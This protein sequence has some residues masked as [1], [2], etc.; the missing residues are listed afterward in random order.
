MKK[1]IKK[2]GKNPQHAE[3]SE[4]IIPKR[5]HTTNNQKITSHLKQEDYPARQTNNLR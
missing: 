5:L 2:Y 3:Y 1:N 4:Q